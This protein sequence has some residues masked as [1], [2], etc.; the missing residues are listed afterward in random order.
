MKSTFN[1][2]Q[3][4][5]FAKYAVSTIGL[6]CLAIAVFAAP[7]WH[8]LDREVVSRAEVIVVGRMK[9]GSLTFLS[10]AANT[11][12]QTDSLSP[13]HQA[14][15]WEHHL[16]LIISE[17]LKGQV[18]ATSLVVS[19]KYGLD[20]FVGGC[21][22][23][24]FTVI[25]IGDT[26]YAKDVVQIFDTGSS[27]RPLRAITGDI[28]TNHIWLLRHDQAQNS[29]GKTN[30]GPDIIAVYDPEDIQP[31]ARRAELLKYLK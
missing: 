8:Y 3:I 16:E 24:Q 11:N 15:T 12:G 14:P 7:R 13:K 1:V 6:L 27:T 31:V 29:D 5:M 20:P 22:S 18:S 28:R 19:V 25:N 2:M 10:R 9:A 23:N 4:R 30:S 26:N 17:V 21:F